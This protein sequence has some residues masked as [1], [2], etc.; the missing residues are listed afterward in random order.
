M[1]SYTIILNNGQIFN[2]RAE[3]VEY[4]PAQ[5]HIRLI[6]DKRIIARF[7]MD[8]I[9]GWAEMPAER[10]KG[11]MNLQKYVEHY[12]KAPCFY[13]D[14]LNK[15]DIHFKKQ[16]EKDLS[17]RECETCKHS[18]NG[19]VNATETCHECMW[20]SEYEPKEDKE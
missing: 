12:D 19:H 4:V 13:D 16:M 11:N 9:A 14:V 17:I 18:K 1:N 2:V 15:V 7:N 10:L 5:N 20:E 3:Q 8:N 6:K